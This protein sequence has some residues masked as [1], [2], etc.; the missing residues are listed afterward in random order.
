MKNILFLLAIVLGVMPPALQAGPPCQ[1]TAFCFALKAKEASA[2]LLARNPAGQAGVSMQEL[3]KL[4]EQ[5]RAR[6]LGTAVVKGESGLRAQAQGKGFAL[7]AEMVA[8]PDG[9]ALSVVAQI[10]AGGETL[11]S[12][13]LCAKE[14]FT[15]AGN[16]AP[17]K[18]DPEATVYLVYLL[19]GVSGG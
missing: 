12:G 8:L 2:F 15:F 10:T 11:M 3:E 18:D 7:D 13:V 16:T 1:I 19:A 17:E 9:R 14:Q 5:G 6:S 4:V